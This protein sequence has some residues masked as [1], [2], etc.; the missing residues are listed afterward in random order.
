MGKTSVSH[1]LLHLWP[2]RL[3]RHDNTEGVCTLYEKLE[4]K[5]HFD[6]C[7][8]DGSIQSALNVSVAASTDKMARGFDD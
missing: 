7:R 2:L 1:L 5:C 8:H 3:K 4:T 6:S